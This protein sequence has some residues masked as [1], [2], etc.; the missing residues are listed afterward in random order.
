VR[1]L[2]DSRLYTLTPEVFVPTVTGHPHAAREG[3]ELV[4]A[5]LEPDAA[6]HGR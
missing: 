5:R 4:R 6:Q 3:A 2:T 1:T